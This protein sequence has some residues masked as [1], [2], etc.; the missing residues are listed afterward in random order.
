MA[1]LRLR[2]L[3]VSLIVLVS[4]ICLTAT[5][6]HSQIISLDD[7]TVPPT[8]GVGHDYIKLG[9]CLTHQAPIPSMWGWKTIRGT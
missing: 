5:V 7:T 3:F 4:T 9:I 1:R 6:A 2:S 8:P